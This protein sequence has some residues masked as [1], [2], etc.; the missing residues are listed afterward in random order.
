M[1]FI[2]TALRS[3]E[4]GSAAADADESPCRMPSARASPLL[5]DNDGEECD[6]DGD[7]VDGF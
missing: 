3:D 4:E 1:R 6:S 2:L 5:V 7:G